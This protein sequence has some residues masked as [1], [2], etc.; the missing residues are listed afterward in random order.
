MTRVTITLQEVEGGTKVNILHEGLPGRESTE[1]PEGF[2][3]SL[4]NLPAA[5]EA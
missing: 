1:G 5:M 2:G 3:E 4:A